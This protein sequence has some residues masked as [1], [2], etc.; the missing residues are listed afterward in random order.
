VSLVSH[1][2]IDAYPASHKEEDGKN[3]VFDFFEGFLFDKQHI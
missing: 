2:V 1:P 3:V